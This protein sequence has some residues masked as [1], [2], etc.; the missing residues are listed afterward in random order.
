MSRD[1]SADGVI[2]RTSETDEPCGY[3]R[4]LSRVFFSYN[5]DANPDICPDC[6][7]V[8]EEAPGMFTGPSPFP[9]THW[10]V[11]DPTGLNVPPMGLRLGTED[12]SRE[13]IADLIRAAVRYGF[14]AA[15]MNGRE[16]NLDP[17]ALVQNI[18]VGLLGYWTAD[19]LSS[20]AWGNPSPVPPQASIDTNDD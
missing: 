8:T 3:C 17:D 12:P 9:R 14:R 6:F 18:V 11:A 5:P 7:A 10:S 20:D 16:P 2:S 13:R 19:G 15:T 1:N 4:Q